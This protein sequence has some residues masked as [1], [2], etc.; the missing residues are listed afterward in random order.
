MSAGRFRERAALL[1]LALVLVSTGC[2]H[3]PKEVPLGDPNRSSSPGATG[4]PSPAGPRIIRSGNLTIT[5]PPA[6]DPQAEA[7]FKGYQ[8]FWEGLLKALAAANPGEP[9]HLATTT[10][11]ARS[12]FG[13]HLV[14][15]QLG[16]R[17]QSGPTRLH[18]T[19]TSVTGTVALLTDCADLSALRVRNSSGQPVNPPDPKTT[20][21]SVELVLQAGKWVV[22][23]YDENV[24]GC[25]PATAG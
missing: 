25:T 10:G 12:L 21:I 5:L 1:A 6:G 4:S 16:R 13:N 22:R 24:R 18:P 15:L 3:K 8:A 14:N 17:T 2:S 20:Q 11:G 7:V 9:S 19:V 23:K